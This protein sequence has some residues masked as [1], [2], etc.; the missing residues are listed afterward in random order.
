M[1]SIH[2][3]WRRSDL[4][5][6]WISRSISFPDRSF[7]WRGL[8]LLTWKIVRKFGDSR[9]NL[10]DMYGDPGENLL[11]ILAVVIIFLSPISSV[12]DIF[13]H[14]DIL[15]AQFATELNKENNEQ[16]HFRYIFIYI[17]KIY[18]HTCK[19]IFIYIC[20]YV[21]ICMN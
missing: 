16:A 17:Y 1:L 9:E 15:R 12:R 3:S 2:R 19:C 7:E 6:H 20:I 4:K 14:V 8:R 11:E 10:F 21:Y 13:Q 5:K 18:I